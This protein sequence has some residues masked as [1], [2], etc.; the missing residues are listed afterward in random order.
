LRAHPGGEIH[1]DDDAVIEGGVSI[2]ATESVYI[3]PR[4]HIGAFC[5][6]IDNHFHR[7]DGDREAWSESVRVVVGPDAVVG[8][9]AIL[10]PGAE[11]GAR[12]WVGAGRVLSSRIL[13]GREL[14]EGLLECPV[15]KENA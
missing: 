6:I 7:V 8:P 9:H 3:G 4:A 1:I 5:K 11:L 15:L 12:A 14:V 2:E 13:A 10:L